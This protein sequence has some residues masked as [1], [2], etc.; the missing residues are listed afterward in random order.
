MVQARLSKRSIN[1]L[2]PKAKPYVVFDGELS[3]PGFGVRVMPSRFKSFFLSY[4]PKGRDGSHA[5][6]L[7]R[8][9]AQSVPTA[10]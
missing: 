4:R 1:A 8:S 5:G 7:R 3:M 2:K 6:V 10:P 9:A